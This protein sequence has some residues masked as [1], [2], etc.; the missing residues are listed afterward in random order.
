MDNIVSLVT[1]WGDGAVDAVETE[2]LVLDAAWDELS[3]VQ[4]SGKVKMAGTGQ[5]LEGQFV[6]RITSA[7]VALSRGGF[8]SIEQEAVLWVR[9]QGAASQIPSQES[10]IDRV[11]T[12]DKWVNVSNIAREEAAFRHAQTLCQ[13]VAGCLRPLESS[14][15]IVCRSTEDALAVAWRDSGKNFTS[16]PIGQLDAAAS[17]LRKRSQAP[18]GGGSTHL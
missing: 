18:L 14:P 5:D 4:G 9:G 17:L 12:L 7:M 8:V 16:D 3:N 10:C 1:A 13:F 6:T 15:G 2:R 11:R